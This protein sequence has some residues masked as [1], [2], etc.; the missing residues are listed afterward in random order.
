MHRLYPIRRLIRIIRNLFKLAF[1]YLW[2]VWEGVGHLVSIILFSNRCP[3]SVKSC[4]T[5]VGGMTHLNDI[6][7]EPKIEVI[8]IWYWEIELDKWYL[9]GPGKSKWYLIWG[10]I[11]IFP[12]HKYSFS[13]DAASACAKKF[14]APRHYIK[15]SAILMSNHF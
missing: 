3:R 11:Y 9:D 10:P 14:G 15:T 12:I 7:Y 4:P 5:M 13:S 6:W 2:R 1:L 8:D